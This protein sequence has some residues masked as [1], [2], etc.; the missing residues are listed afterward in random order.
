[1]Q[2]T[3]L[4]GPS[5][6]TILEHK[7]KRIQTNTFLGD[8]A[9]SSPAVVGET[10]YFYFYVESVPF[11]QEVLPGEVEMAGSGKTCVNTTFAGDCSI[12]LNTPGTYEVTLRYLGTNLY[13]PSE[14]SPT[15]SHTVSKANT[16]VTVLSVTN[17]EPGLTSTIS[18]EVIPLAPGKG[19]P[20]GTV[21][22]FL[23]TGPETCSSTLTQ[24]GPNKSTGSCTIDWVTNGSNTLKAKYFASTQ[25]KANTGTFPI[26]IGFPQ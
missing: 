1:Y 4:F 18:F 2:G 24:V 8:L 10:L 23:T 16:V 21:D 6:S 9:G 22:V 19:A 20:L 3:A 15:F 7:I 13:A 14:M 25:F 11:I 12:R 17:Q 5:T 26:F